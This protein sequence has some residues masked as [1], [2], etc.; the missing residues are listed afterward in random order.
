MTVPP[1][2]AKRTPSP[3]LRWGIL[4]L[5]IGASLLLGP[6]SEVG[7][8]S[9]IDA[10]YAQLGGER[11]FLGAP[12]GPEHSFHDGRA[13]DYR[14]G[15]IFWSAAS[16]AH[17]VHGA[18]R[19]GWLSGGPF[20]PRGGYST[21]RFPVTDETT[22]RAFTPAGQYELGLYNDF[23]GG[24]I[25]Y[26]DGQ[27][28]RRFRCERTFAPCSPRLCYPK[29]KLRLFPPSIIEGHCVNL[30]R[31]RSCDP[32]QVAD[33]LKHSPEGKLDPITEQATGF[34][35]TPI[36]KIT[37]FKGWISTA[38]M[39]HG[40]L[41][42]PVRRAQHSTDGYWTID[43]KIVWMQVGR[44]TITER[45]NKYIR[46]EVR[47]D[48]RAAHAAVNRHPPGPR[49][50]VSFG[51]LL[52][53]DHTTEIKVK[54]GKIRITVVYGFLEVHPN[55]EFGIN[56]APSAPPPAPAPSRGPAPAPAPAP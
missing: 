12:V 41:G 27:G 16:G 40:A 34:I 46:L 22:A 18:I 53:R 55:L 38:C 21:M 7:A 43:L 29:L 11:G 17:E 30:P 33:H 36:K 10:K 6:A 52:Q 39:T 1:S 5:L 47:P 2:A 24:S 20:T 23:Q 44:R 31:T 19:E 35:T 49:D 37:G 42:R 26:R 8:S 4:G 14:G 54:I 9:V 28:E 51:G 25:F 56:P 13:R 3:W 45:D 48:H 15:S 32:G 50:L